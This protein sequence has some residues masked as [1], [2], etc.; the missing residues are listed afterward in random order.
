MPAPAMRQVDRV[1]VAAAPERAWDVARTIDVYR[2]PLARALFELRTLPE[3][4]FARRRG[5]PRTPSPRA[6]I[7]DMAG[8]QSGFQILAEDVGHEVVVGAIGKVWKP[9]IE[10]IRVPPAKYA[11]FEQPGFVK[12]AWCI[13]VDPRLGGGSW[14]TVDVRVGATDGVSLAKFERY[15]TLIGPFSHWI[16]RSILGILTRELGRVTEEARPLPGDEVLGQTKLQTT[17]ATTIE[18]PP[19]QVWPWLLQM[20]CLRAGWYSFDRL[21]NGGIPSANH[22]V[23]E[24]QALEVGDMIPADPKHAGD[25]GVLRLDRGHALVIGSPELLPGVPRPKNAPPWRSSWAFVIEPIGA[26][27]TRL[28]VRLRADYRPSARMTLIKTVMATLHQVMERRQLR[29]IRRRVEAAAT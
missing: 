9:S 12:V 22:I 13:R 5:G 20:G 7:D 24:L 4:L 16:R 28:T 26:D 15:W 3:R 29:N 10:F 17:H 6:R 27:A 21:D 25:F 18:A 8:A 1:P 19:E 14:I 23:P 11:A 2:L